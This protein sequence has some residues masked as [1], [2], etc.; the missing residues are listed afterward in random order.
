MKG[1]PRPLAPRSQPLVIQPHHQALSG[2]NSCY[3]LS[4][5]ANQQLAPSFPIPPNPSKP[6]FHDET[7][8]HYFQV[9]CER[10]ATKIGGYWETGIW[11]RLI[12]EA[13]HQE[14]F[15]RHAIV[16]I[17]ALDLAMEHQALR[18]KTSTGDQGEFADNP[19]HQF[20][21]QKYGKA[22]KLMKDS[23]SEDDKNHVREALISCLLIICFETYRGDLDL[24]VIQAQSAVKVLTSWLRKNEDK[25]RRGSTISA[26]LEKPRVVE[27]DLINTFA[28]LYKAVMVFPAPRPIELSFLLM[29]EAA[30]KLSHMPSIFSTLE[31]A[32][33]TGSSTSKLRCFGII[34][35]VSR[36]SKQVPFQSFT[37]IQ[38]MAMAQTTP[39][40]CNAMF[41]EPN[42]T[43]IVFY[44]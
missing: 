22:L 24:A 18:S 39:L 25:K 31:E 42:L 33:N 35:R 26:T 40:Q 30:E 19:H 38:Y 17:G 37:P 32:Q 13:C 43:K 9:Y 2:E 11:S 36:P 20:A 5:F 15:A 1:P 21:L 12:I 44:I 23:P 3:F 29:S 34:K 16:Y 7:E 4:L 10:T 41:Q 8:A 14:L 28:R 6:L 27:D